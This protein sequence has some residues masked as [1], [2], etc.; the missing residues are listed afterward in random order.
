VAGA[1]TLAAGAGDSLAVIDFLEAEALFRKELAVFVD[2]RDEGKFSAGHIPDALLMP[3][4]DY[5]DGLRRML[6]PKAALVVIYCDGG[7]CELSHDLA[8]LLVRD[9]WRRVR[10]YEGGW[11][12]WESMGMPISTEEAG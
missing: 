9:G 8:R 2:S 12:E 1:D 4:E 11:E 7:D 3:Y 5:R 6:V 10:V